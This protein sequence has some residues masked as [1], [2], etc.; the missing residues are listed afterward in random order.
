MLKS[1]HLNFNHNMANNIFFPRS[2]VA[3]FHLST[4]LAQYA[5]SE[6]IN[7]NWCSQ[8]G[9]ANGGQLKLKEIFLKM[10]R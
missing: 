1:E 7:G 6:S 10:F 8:L 5:E 2:S 3:V 4:V 9:T